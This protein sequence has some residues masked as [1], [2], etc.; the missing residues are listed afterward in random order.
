[1]K[2]SFK[3]SLPY[4]NKVGPLEEDIK[5]F[6]Q[7]Y[8]LLWWETDTDA[9]RFEKTYS[10]SEQIKI[11]KEFTG[12][13]DEVS[14]KFEDYPTDK[15]KQKEWLGKFIDGIK[16]FG[17]KT[18]RLSDLYLDSISQEGFIN[19]TR[20]FVDKV[21]EFHPSLK[22]ENVYQALR[23]VWIMNSLQM[24]LNIDIKPSDAIF[25][26]SMIYPYT[27]NYLDDV[28][29]S[30]E[31]KLSFNSK[32]KNWLEGQLTSPSNK[33]EEK[34]FRL[35]KMIENQYS[36]DKFPDVYRGLLAIF[37]AQIKSLILQKKQSIPYEIN[38][39][40]ISFEKGGTSV[41]TDGLLVNGNLN[42]EQAAF[43]FGF[44]LMLQL[45]DDIQDVSQDMKNNHMTVFSQTAQKYNLDA[46][47][48][49]LF[50]FI[51]RIVDLKLSEEIS[52]QKCLKELILKNCY[53]LVLESIGKNQNFYSQ[54]Y[55]E[56]TCRHFPFRFSY[57]KQLR[58]RLNQ[59]LLEKRKY[60]ADLDLIS[61]VLLT[62]TSRTIS[63]K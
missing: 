42:K 52:S 47:A 44:G 59:L 17:E 36:R 11:E 5:K 30:F 7:E 51:S 39:L 33:Q 53:Y 14:D 4:S 16:K 54:E 3:T 56:K 60:V 43:C 38:I 15:E 23:N 27:D 61:A 28:T 10:E 6:R 35:I 8:S 1:M 45:S 18:F 63:G 41:L 2:S 37:N 26:Y 50:N 21:K 24:Y 29:Q 25:A 40:D 49:K 20:A 55:I 32:L 12:Y 22:I 57:L 62:I 58:K 13:V 46:L 19:S 9:P 31:K 34:I 48:N